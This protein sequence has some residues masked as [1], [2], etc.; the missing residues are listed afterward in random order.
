MAERGGVPLT[1]LLFAIDTKGFRRIK[2]EGLIRVLARNF[3]RSM[4]R[5]A[6]VRGL[7]P[8]ENF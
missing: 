4:Q 7:W 2:E 6:G 8:R 3:R 1:Y 5:S